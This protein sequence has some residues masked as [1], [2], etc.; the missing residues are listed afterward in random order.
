[1]R[2]FTS[3]E[4][5]SKMYSNSVMKFEVSSTQPR[6]A[7]ELYIGTALKIYMTHSS[8]RSCDYVQLS[9]S[10]AGCYIRYLRSRCAS[11]L[12]L[13]DI[14]TNTDIPT[15]FCEDY[16]AALMWLHVQSIQNDADYCYYLVLFISWNI[17]ITPT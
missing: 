1:M 10:V 3:F 5:Y 13:Q 7:A 15:Y 6:Y 16:V 12:Y 14:A 8:G 4:I 11:S 17:K 9:Y 2:R